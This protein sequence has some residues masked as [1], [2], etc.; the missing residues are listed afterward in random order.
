[1]GAPEV[2]GPATRADPTHFI[3]IRKKGDASGLDTLIRSLLRLGLRWEGLYAVTVFESGCKTPPTLADKKSGIVVIDHESGLVSIS[4]H[5]SYR[6][7]H[8]LPSHPFTITSCRA[9]AHPS[10]GRLRITSPM[11]ENASAQQYNEDDSIDFGEL[12]RRLKRGLPLIVGLASLGLAITAGAYFMSGSFL[13]VTTATRVVFS[14][15]GFEKGEYP[16]KSKF[17][18]DDLRS[19][20]IV[21]EALKREGLDTTQEVQSKVRAALSIEGIIPDNIVKERD[22]QR[23][24]GQTPRLYVPDEYTLTLS[25]PGKFP[26]TARQREL[27]LNELVSVYQEKFTRTYVSLPLNTG[28]AFE[29]LVGADYFDYDLVL[30]RESDNITTF[31]TQMSAT[32]RAYRSPRTNLSFSDLLK[33][34][35]LFTQLRLNEVLGLIR[36]DGLSKDRNLAMVKMDYY[37]KT[38]SD[39]E[40]KTVEEEKVVQSLLKQAQEREQNY[41]LGI[42]SQAGQQRTDSPVIDQGLVDSLL[43]N[44]AYNFLVRQSLE[45]SLKTRRIQ[46][47]RAILQERRDNMEAF[48]KSDVAQKGE[49]LTQFQASLDNL[50][51]VYDSLINDIRQTYEDYQQQQYG[52]A[53]RVSMQTKTSSFYRGLAMAGIAG[54]GIGLAAGLGLALLGIGRRNKA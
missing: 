32:A 14:F 16:D 45:T 8:S 51:H 30:S 44:D 40:R 9:A 11:N 39:N 43:V 37:L 6:F 34:S 2:G 17:Q 3:R 28:K 38:L 23:A 50:K 54:L 7:S 12:F 20:E 24:S 21:A 52:D 22:K 48:I 27:L 49:L 15:P 46:S 1:M 26:L 53:V 41:T 42:K 35:Q 5:W 10:L 13:T 4:P 19:P 31:L 47:E 25:L 29:S 36:R 18:P 33:Q